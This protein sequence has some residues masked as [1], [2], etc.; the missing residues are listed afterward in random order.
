MFSTKGEVAYVQAVGMVQSLSDLEIDGNEQLKN[1]IIDNCNTFISFCINSPKNGK[2]IWNK[3][4]TEVT[5]QILD[6][7]RT[8]VG[9]MKDVDQFKVHPDELKNL[10]SG[11]G[12]FYFKGNDS[13]IN[14]DPS[15]FQQGMS[16]S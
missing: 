6:F 12:C 8:G 11:I 5:H 4:A 9:T 15:H 3:P 2:N 7:R 10:D 14:N 1:Q 13:L 16:I